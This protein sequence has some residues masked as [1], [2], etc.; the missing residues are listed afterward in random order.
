[1]NY[2]CINIASGLFKIKRRFEKTHFEMKMFNQARKIKENVIEK[3]FQLQQF[4]MNDDL[5]IHTKEI[6]NYNNLL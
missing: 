6:F 2:G 1:M 3:D 4:A 5:I